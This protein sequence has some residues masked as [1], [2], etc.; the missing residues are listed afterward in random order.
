MTHIRSMTHT[1]EHDTHKAHDTHQKRDTDKKH[2]PSLY[3]LAALEVHFDR[4]ARCCLLFRLHRQR[5]QGLNLGFGDVG[6]AVWG[7]DLKVFD[8]TPRDMLA[9]ASFVAGR[10][11][12]MRRY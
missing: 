8:S 2:G 6:F 4:L 5:N 7:L 1:E 9:L 3:L 12:S 10:R 11:R